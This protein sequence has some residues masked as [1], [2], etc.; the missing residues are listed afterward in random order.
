MLVLVRFAC[1]T[2]SGVL[3]HLQFNH[4][5]NTI[6][7]PRANF[8]LTRFLVWIFIGLRTIENA[9]LVGAR[10]GPADVPT[11]IKCMSDLGRSSID[12]HSTLQAQQW[13][14]R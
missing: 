11:K 2:G 1:R 4:P 5:I 12:S 10:T 7:L 13:E 9:G 8:K 6:R 3:Q 14:D